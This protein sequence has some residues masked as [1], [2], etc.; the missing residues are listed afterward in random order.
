MREYM[1]GYKRKHY[2]QIKERERK[3]YQSHREKILKFQKEHYPYIKKGWNPKSSN[4][5]KG[6]TINVGR[7]QSKEWIEKRMSEETKRKIKENHADLSG[8]KHPNWNGGKIIKHCIVCGKSL[9]RNK[10][11]IDAGEGKYCSGKC[12]GE[13]RVGKN[14]ANWQGGM[15][16]EP[17]TLSFNQQ[18]KDRIRV[19]DNFTCQ[20]CGVP[21]LECF[22]RLDVHHIDYDKKNCKEDNLISLCNKCNIRANYNKEY[23]TKYYQEKIREK[24]D[25]IS[26]K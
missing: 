9:K 25:F 19:R 12:A 8:E 23:W 11:K 4:F 20:E 14:S 24:L 22:R 10:A 7:H 21:E 18:L 26:L 15:S 13:A 3:Y 5:I 17:Y 2:I 6:H 16:F 1:R